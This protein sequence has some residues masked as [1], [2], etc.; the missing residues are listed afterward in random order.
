MLSEAQKI[1]ASRNDVKI[2]EEA[3]DLDELYEGNQIR[4]Y[5]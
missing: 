1:F 4:V 3:Y 5:R 2:E